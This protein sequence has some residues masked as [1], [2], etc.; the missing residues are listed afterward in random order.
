MAA[1]GRKV[2]R[3]VLRSAFT[4]ADFGDGLVANP[5][6]AILS[7]AMMLSWLATVE[8]GEAVAR[9]IDAR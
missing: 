9:A 2:I 3:D 5:I 8:V 1:A 7:A 4:L 6:G